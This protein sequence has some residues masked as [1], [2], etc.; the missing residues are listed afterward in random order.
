MRTP[1]L[2]TN[3]AA[4]LSFHATKMRP[5]HMLS[6]QESQSMRRLDKQLII[7]VTGL[8]MTGFTIVLIAGCQPA[9]TYAV[10]HAIART[11]MDLKTASIEIQ[12]YASDRGAVPK[13]LLSPSN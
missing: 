4:A 7:G 13:P 1:S 11:K 5:L 6:L 9:D 8:V 3:T 2:A 12:L 10:N